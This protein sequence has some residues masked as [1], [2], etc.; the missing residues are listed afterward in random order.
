MGYNSGLRGLITF[1]RNRSLDISTRVLVDFEPEY[2]GSAVQPSTEARYFSLFLIVQTGAG[3]HPSFYSADTRICFPEDK[4]VG[5]RNCFLLHP[6]PPPT[7]HDSV[8]HVVQITT[9]GT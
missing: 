4:T 6:S 5:T 3:A 9:E 7:F 1:V 8:W 2:R